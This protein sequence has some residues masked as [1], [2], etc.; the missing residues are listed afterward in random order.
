MKKN[1]YNNLNV[2]KSNNILYGTYK[3]NNNYK[4]RE[5][6]ILAFRVNIFQISNPSPYN[7]KLLLYIYIYCYKY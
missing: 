5:K 1:K 4:K 7:I 3:I 2:V 6:N